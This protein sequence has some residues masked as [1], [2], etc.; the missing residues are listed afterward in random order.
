MHHGTPKGFHRT[1]R[2]LTPASSV[3]RDSA[4]AAAQGSTMSEREVLAPA[5]RARTR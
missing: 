2:I 1:D 4:S 5:L 3:R